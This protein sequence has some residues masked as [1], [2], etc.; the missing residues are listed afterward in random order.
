M[1]NHDIWNMQERL[2]EEITIKLRK[3]NK[4]NLKENWTS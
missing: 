2:N 3:I 1:F 4:F